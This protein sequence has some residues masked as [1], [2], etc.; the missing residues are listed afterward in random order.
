MKLT[1][2]SISSHIVSFKLTVLYTVM[3]KLKCPS[4]FGESFIASSATLPLSELIAARS[5][6]WLYPLGLTYAAVSSLSICARLVRGSVQCASIY[7]CIEC[8]LLGRLCLWSDGSEKKRTS[9]S[10][11]WVDLNKKFCSYS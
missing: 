10:E 5:N 3:S 6:L 2:F 9:V 1:S 8:S 11:G 4:E 7:Y